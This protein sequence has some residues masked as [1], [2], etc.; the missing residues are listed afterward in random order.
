M[1]WS[2]AYK[3]KATTN[4]IDAFIADAN[5]H[6]LKLDV[7]TEPYLW[8]KQTKSTAQG[9][10]KIHFAADPKADFIA[11][12]DHLTHLGQKWNGV[13]IIVQ[14]YYYIQS[15]NILKVNIQKIFD[16]EESRIKA[17]ADVPYSFDHY[18][19]QF[20]LKGKISEPVTELQKRF[21]PNFNT[22]PIMIAAEQLKKFG[23]EEVYAR[24][25]VFKMKT[26]PPDWNMIFVKLPS[27]N[28]LIPQFFENLKNIFSILGTPTPNAK[29]IALEINEKAN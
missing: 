16:D 13:K 18:F 5:S 7:K 9:I 6:S 22:H 1:G 10:T 25:I 26:Q 2:I 4:E 17:T 28:S 11:I 14:D 27:E 19:E 29:Y 23:A 20:E 21:D 8:E 12:I 24:T 3:A 15:K